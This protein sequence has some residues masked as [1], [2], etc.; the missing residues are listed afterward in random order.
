MCLFSCFQRL[1]NYLALQFF[2]YERIRLRLFQKRIVRTK[3]DICVIIV[4]RNILTIHNVC[5]YLHELINIK[6]SK[7]K[8]YT[9]VV[10]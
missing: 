7:V 9:L 8:Q 5:K 10:A 3:L 2:D 1:L 6:G 4:F